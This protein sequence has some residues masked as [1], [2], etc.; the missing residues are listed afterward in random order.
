MGSGIKAGVFPIRTGV[1]TMVEEASEASFP[2]VQQMPRTAMMHEAT[3]KRISMTNKVLSFV[4]E[5]F[6]S[7]VI[8]LATQ[9]LVSG[10]GER[11]RGSKRWRLPP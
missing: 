4:R 10:L 11:Q 3:I 1:R 5:G 8:R 6:G 9:I 7:R 2:H